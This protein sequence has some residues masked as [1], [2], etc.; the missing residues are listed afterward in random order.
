MKILSCVLIPLVLVLGANGEIRD[1]DDY[2]EYD[3]YDD[4]YENDDMC[5]GNDN[6][7]FYSSMDETC[8]CHHQQF[9]RETLEQQFGGNIKKCC[10]FHGY[11]YHLS[12]CEV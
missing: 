3:S 12:D 8:A 4:D 10:E 5:E 11:R 2:T 1:Y 9:P 6:C 7:A